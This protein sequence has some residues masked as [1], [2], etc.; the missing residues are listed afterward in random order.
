MTWIFGIGIAVYLVMQ[1]IGSTNALINTH[2]FYLV[3]GGTVITILL[4]TPHQVIVDLFRLFFNSFKSERPLSKYQLRQ[5]IQ[6]PKNT[7][8]SYGIV[9]QARELWELGVTKE[10][11]ERLLYY[12]AEGILNRHL[13]AIATLR[14]LGKYPPSLG[15]IGTVIGM[16]GLFSGL[17]EENQKTIGAELAL[18][19]TATLYGLILANLV[20]LPLADRL[21]AIEE[22]RRANIDQIL[23]VLI[24]IN[25]DQPA[26]VSENLINVA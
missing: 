16:I 14:N 15:M 8:D 24:S 13:A 5:L 12:R 10:E 7:H 11:F 20:V 17:S 18:A 26:G 4:M 2:S 3:F 1:E 21:E 25:L 22:A 23:K 6:D 9:E 19:M